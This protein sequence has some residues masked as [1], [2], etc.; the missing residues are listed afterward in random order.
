[1]QH[2]KYKRAVVWFRT[3]LRIADNSAL[4]AAVE[5]ADEVIP[6]FVLDRSIL[7]RADTG[8]ARVI[9]MLDALKHLDANL[10]SRGSRLF[11]RQGVAPDEAIRAVRELEA[12]AVF[13]NR[14]YEAY[15]RTR[16][17]SFTREMKNH[18]VTVTA[19]DDYVLHDP[20]EVLTQA[21][22]FYTVFTPYKRSWFERP[23]SQ[24]VSAPTRIH[25]PN[26]ILSADIPTAKDMGLST[27]QHFECGGENAAS[28]LLSQFVAQ[29]LQDYPEQRDVPGV[30]GTSHLSK[31]LHFGTI[32]PRT[33]FSAVNGKS[34]SDVF[35]NE[36]A[37][38]DFYVQVMYNFP[39]VEV[40][41]FKRDLN[42]IE[43][44]GGDSW[45]DAWVAGQTGYPIVDAA[46]RQLRDEAWM[47]NRCRM[48]VASFL[49]KDLLIDW[50]RGELYF[51]QMLV[52]GD[53]AANNGGWQWSAG[54]GT[55]AQPYF[56]IFNPVSQGEKFD[57]R[58]EYVRKYIPELA[59]VPDKYVHK[60]W[61][62]SPTEQAYV[63]CRIGIDY[64]APIV[65][66]AVQRTAALALYKRAASISHQNTV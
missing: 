33:I 36:I 3:D 54:T 28:A 64:P 26:D 65:D 45:F 8:L 58:G 19:F 13:F 4:A 60:P 57:P 11:L 9:F 38:R 20:G 34:G 12:D 42:N 37:W 31:H 52:D 50:R 15:A 24:P 47:H 6:L 41:S 53:K 22:G 55:D 10:R 17:D 14:D 40:G 7:D 5:T 29:S 16:D 48:I 62:L 18:G 23:V 30:A 44:T 66:H 39:H 2:R 35:L 32:S 49:T 1:M 21:V 46:M 25:S 61:L 56:R 63:G 59:K 27:L 43:W 51:M